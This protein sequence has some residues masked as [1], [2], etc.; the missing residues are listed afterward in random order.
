MLPLA[1][2]WHGASNGSWGALWIDC[3]EVAILRWVKPRDMPREKGRKMTWA[4][5]NTILGVQTWRNAMIIIPK[6]W[7]PTHFE[8]RPT[9]RIP[10]PDLMKRGFWIFKNV[11]LEEFSAVLTTSKMGGWMLF[12]KSKY[13]IPLVRELRNHYFRIR[14]GE[15]LVD[16]GMVGNEFR[17]LFFAASIERCANNGGF[18]HART[19]AR[20]IPF[21]LSWS[22]EQIPKCLN[23]WLQKNNVYSLYTLK[24]VASE[25]QSKN[26]NDPIKY[27][28]P[29]GFR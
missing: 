17:Q 26:V 24:T 27:Q 23:K 10:I 22:K 28:I 15:K 12:M 19:K 1:N 14:T 7:A 20:T 11:A 6:N 9:E 2:W 29:S 5:K 13:K 16:V 21:G 3:L 18:F 8:R 25:D 4:P